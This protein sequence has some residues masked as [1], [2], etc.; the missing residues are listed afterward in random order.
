MSVQ[1]H[2]M[3]WADYAA[4]LRRR[5]RLTVLTM[6]LIALGSIYIAYTLPAVYE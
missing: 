5:W 1:A 6:A 3:T 2:D 4:V